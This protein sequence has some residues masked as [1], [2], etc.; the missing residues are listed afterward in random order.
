[1][2]HSDEVLGRWASVMLGADAYAEVVDRHLELASDVTW[3]SSLLD[4]SE[5][6]DV[7]IG[8]WRKSRSSAAVQLLGEVDDEQLV[9]RLV[10]F[11]QF[12]EELDRGTLQLALRIVPLQWW[13]SRIGTTAPISSVVPGPAPPDL[14]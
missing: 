2:S 11:T 6:T 13:A 9:D 14:P 3:L 4:H 8:R 7:D 1:V 12:A 5:P 10:A